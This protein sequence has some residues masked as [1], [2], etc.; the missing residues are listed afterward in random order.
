MLTV[1]LYRMV[2]KGRL[3][4]MEVVSSGDGLRQNVQMSGRSKECESV[5]KGRGS[6]WIDEGLSIQLF[7]WMS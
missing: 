3:P 1:S 4:L 2:S 6:V 5:N 7:A